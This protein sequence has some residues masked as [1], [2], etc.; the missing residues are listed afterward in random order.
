MFDAEAY[1]TDLGLATQGSKHQTPG[2]L[3]THC[4]FCDPSAQKD[5]GGWRLKDGKFHCWKCGWHDPLDVIMAM[6]NADWQRAKQIL[7][8]YTIRG[9]KADRIPI[10]QARKGGA[11]VLRFPPGAAPMK[12]MHI[13]YL[14]ERGFN[15]E[16]LEHTWELMGVGPIGK[17]RF[18]IIIPIK[19][20]RGVSVSYQGRDITGKRNPPY[21][22]CK[23]EEEVVHHKHTLYG[24]QHRH[25]HIGVIVEG[26]ADA[27]RIGPGALATFGTGWTLEQGFALCRPPIKR[28]FLLYDPEPLA[29]QSAERL[30]YLLA[31]AGK[32]VNQITLDEG[33]P[34]DMSPSDAKAFRK[35]VGL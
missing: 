4:P 21:L 16:E 24:L 10:L 32:E 8:K 18:R 15:A 22:A 9:L 6:E 26:V 12:D 1:L 28:Y 5:H 2:W 27:W 31:Q 19:D 7:L 11:S 33:D 35:E 3:N 20:E 29:Q 14:C 17:F 30:G 13:N 25:E 23:T 34:G